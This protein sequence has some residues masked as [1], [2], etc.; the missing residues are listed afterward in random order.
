MTTPDYVKA[1]EAALQEHREANAYTSH[2]VIIDRLFERRLE[3]TEAYAEIY[4]KVEGHPLALFLFFDGLLLVTEE[5]N[6]EKV[7]KSRE[8]RNQIKQVNQEIAKVAEKLAQL[9]DERDELNTHSGFYSDTITSPTELIDKAARYDSHD[10]RRLK[11]A[12]DSISWKLDSKYWP[13]LNT[14]VRVISDDAA[15]PQIYASNR[16]TEAATTGSR[17]GDADYFKALEHRWIDEGRSRGTPLPANLELSNGAMA[18][19]A[20]CALDRHADRPFTSDFVKNL[21][22]RERKAEALKQGATA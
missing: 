20:T 16:T 5:W 8:G 19:L 2:A 3:L 17:K 7:A 10:Y 18:S 9:L 13:S 14:C 1:C 12:M 21:R 22:H 15:D 4:E 6:P 11:D